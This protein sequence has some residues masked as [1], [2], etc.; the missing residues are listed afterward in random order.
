MLPPPSLQ[1]EYALIYSGD[2]ALTL[3]A[4]ETERANALRIARE[5]GR[6]AA[7]TLAGQEPTVFMFRPIH[8]VARTWMAN[9]VRARQ[10]GP[11]AVLE[12][13]FRL[14]LVSVTGLPGVELKHER[15]DGLAILT[16]ATM[17]Q[18][19]SLGT[20]DQGRDVV[21]ELGDIVL[22]RTLQGVP[23]KS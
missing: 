2:S 8:G 15:V 7:I 23:P 18:F 21:I 11:D 17:D 16:L 14:A 3:P 1:T 9:A 22:T 19:Y 4:D 6:W 5:T 12:L 20:G 10:L 13:V